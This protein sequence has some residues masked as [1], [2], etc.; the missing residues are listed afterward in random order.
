M[1]LKRI[2][3]KNNSNKKKNNN[4]KNIKSQLFTNLK[5][6]LKGVYILRICFVFNDANIFIT[7][8]IFQIAH[9][10]EEIFPKII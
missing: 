5:E 6:I 2:R 4:Y 9:L 10:F 1:I 7:I 8:G 3:A